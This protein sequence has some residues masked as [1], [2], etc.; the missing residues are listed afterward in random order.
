MLDFVD[1]PLSEVLNEFNRRNAVQLV[2]GDSV[3]L[4]LSITATVHTGRPEEFVRILEFT[5]GIVARRENN[6][7]IVLVK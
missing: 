6:E 5:E 1:A 3:L 2:V 7:R 4:D